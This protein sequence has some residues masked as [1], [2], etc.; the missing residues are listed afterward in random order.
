MSILIPCPQCNRELKLPDRALLGRK[1]KCPKCGHTFVL[2]ESTAAPPKPAQSD[3]VV[4]N[5]QAANEEPAT[6]L[7]VPPQLPSNPV[8]ESAEP[9]AAGTGFL[10]NFAS[11]EKTAYS[12]GAATRLQDL[13]RRRSRGRNVGIAIAT[14]FAA[15]L[16]TGVMIASRTAEKKRPLTIESSTTNH[17][18]A[19]TADSQTADDTDVENDGID[20]AQTHYAKFGSPTGGKPVE[21]QY[22]PFGTQLIFNIHPATMWKD[23]RF[24]ELRECV[25]PLAELIESTIKSLFNCKPEQIEELLICLIPGTRGTLPEIAA[26]AHLDDDQTENQLIEQLGRKA[27]TYDRP[28][29]F[30]DQR[31]YLIASPKTLVVCPKNQVD[32]MIQAINERHPVEQIDPL[33]PLT[34]R[35][36]HVTIIMTPLTLSLQ[37][38]WFPE[39]LRPFVK[40][41]LDW[42]GD[43]I[44][45]VAWS[46][47]LNDELFFSDFLLRN[48]T[49]PGKK[50][51][52][53][54]KQKLAELAENLVPRFE[55]MNPRQLGKRM[56]I[57]RVPA[58]IEVFSMATITAHGPRHA[59][60]TTPL[61]TKAAANLFLGTYLAWDESTRTDFS[62]AKPVPTDRQ[63]IPATIAERL[64][65]KIDVDFRATPLSEAFAYISG[66][67]KTPIEID[68][69]AIKAG[70]FTKNLKQSF[71]LDAATVQQV[72]QKIFEESKGV[73]P[74]PEK[75]LII[76][77]DE[78]QKKLVVTTSAAASKR[79]NEDMRM[80]DETE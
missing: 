69:D 10:P 12:M 60:L 37:D 31:A 7:Q 25:P 24:H 56:I 27:D 8:Q 55:Q 44:E 78:N 3:P 39:N 40:N 45:A 72:I 28:I 74:N 22:I 67:I 34:D 19:P 48:K 52:R 30:R 64:K 62:K 26:V 71:R 35:D 77:V 32:E 58:M 9:A 80:K 70:G 11:L 41:S 23:E 75:H 63:Q 59:R 46:F 29:Y 14:V 50:L 51:E 49:G 53:S 38:S 57:G 73:E 20:P 2:K 6:N 42:L 43:E 76:L 36:R 5:E 4:D 33:L 1:G 21:L 18:E 68:G 79:K 47:H 16:V 66:E 15:I 17:A 13:Q 65:L 61:P 54:F